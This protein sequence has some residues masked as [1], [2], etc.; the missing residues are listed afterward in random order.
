MI[1][2]SESKYL[3]LN[4]RDFGP[5]ESADIDLRPMTVFVGP[6]NTGKSYLAIL[7]YALHRFFSGSVIFS[8]DVPPEVGGYTIFQFERS[9]QDQRTIS[10]EVTDALSVWVDETVSKILNES[11]GGTFP[12]VLPESASVPLRTRLRDIREQGALLNHEVARCFGVVSTKNLI[13]FGT[14]EGF[15]VAVKLPATENFGCEFT[16]QEGVGELMATIPDHVTLRLDPSTIGVSDRALAQALTWVA[17]EARKAETEN[18]RQY[19]INSLINEVAAVI[20]YQYFMPLTR[21]G[22]YLPA[23][24]TG[25]MDSYKAVVG[26]LIHQMSQSTFPR[27][28]SHPTLTGV[29]SD[30]LVRLTTLGEVRRSEPDKILSENIERSILSGL[31]RMEKSEFGISEF[32]YRPDGWD[33]DLRLANTSSMVSELAPVVLYLRYIVR[34]GEVLIIEEPEAHLHPA[35]QVE[36]VRHLAAAVRAGVRIMLTTHSEWILEELSNLVHLSSLTESQRE[37][38][39]RASY[40][41]S[42]E[43]VG[44]WLFGPKEQP[45]GS[46]VREIPFDAEDGGFVT[47]YEDVGIRTHNDWARISNRLT[48]IDAE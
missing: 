26:S 4:V 15:R 23:A 19:F 20:G 41:L 34:P 10:R 31:V 22:Y 44:V 40:A 47:D 43:D 3:Q 18:R 16:V 11:T 12:P 17:S 1:A 42:P 21:M 45:E 13:R 48:E 7:T 29:M 38:I 9:L 35:M 33:Y 36:F 32:L 2:S 24:R 46:V 8:G 37:G 14:R 39:G 25:V 28:E 6:S 5:I 27:T 30:F